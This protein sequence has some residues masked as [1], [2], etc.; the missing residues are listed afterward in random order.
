M[1]EIRDKRTI[2]HEAPVGGR[3]VVETQYD[4]RVEERSGLSGAAIAAMVVAAVIAAIF[5]TWL[6]LNNRQSEDLAMERERALIAERNAAQSQAAQQQQPQQQ[7]QQPNVIVLPQTQPSTVPVPMPMPSQAEPAALPT[8]SISIEVDVNRRLLDDKQLG[9]YPITAKIENGTV[10]LSG[11]LP[12]EDLKT[13]AEK[14]VSSVK[15]V[16][17]VIND[18]IVQ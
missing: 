15:G 8:S 1:D 17:R 12:H 3:P 6:I 13:R 9:S 10:T 4:H 11:T 7:A 2:I 18:I 5:I 14:V 16:R